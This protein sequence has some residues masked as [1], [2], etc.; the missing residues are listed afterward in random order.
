MDN[1]QKNTL[2][3]GA[4]V[5]RGVMQLASVR[6]QFGRNIECPT[7]YAPVTDNGVYRTPQ[8]AN[9]T[10]LRVKAGGNAADTA[11]G[12]GARS[13][14]LYGIN[15]TGDLITETIATAGASASTATAQTFIRLYLAEVHESGTYGTQTTASHVGNITIENAAGTEDWAQIQLNGFAASSTAIGTITVPR[16]HIGLVFGIVVNV[17]NTKST[18]IIILER[19]GILDAAPP[20]KPIKKVQ[21]FLGIAATNRISFDMP[22]KFAELTDVG[23]LAKVA[24]GTGA[25][26]IDMEV[27]LLE[28]ET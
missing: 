10:A 28:A 4:H 26:S 15:A 25:V 7:T 22:L 21:E 17:D 11:A 6:H 3:W 1:R 8:P 18:D 2:P 19:A 24:N 20:Y 13:V 14:T 12:A 5:A 27:L 23:V 16:N 9:A